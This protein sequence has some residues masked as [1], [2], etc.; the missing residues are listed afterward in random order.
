MIRF[1]L[2]KR[3]IAQ[4]HFKLLT[5]DMSQIWY[6]SLVKTVIRSS[7]WIYREFFSTIQF[8]RIRFSIKWILNW[9]NPFK[10]IPVNTRR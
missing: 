7:L 1:L 3:N 9:N 2:L 5:F 4:L 10:Q 6:L 8:E